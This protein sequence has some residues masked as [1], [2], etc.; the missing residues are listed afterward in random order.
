MTTKIAMTTIMTTTLKPCTSPWCSVRLPQNVIPIHYNLR[1]KANVNELS[2]NG[3][4]SMFVRVTN[5]TKYVLF[6]FKQ[7]NITE[8]KIYKM[9]GY[10]KQSVAIAGGQS[11]PTNEYF[12]IETTNQMQPGNY[13]V[14]VQFQALVSKKLTGFY[15]STYKNQ[16]GQTR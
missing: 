5:A 4:Q 8:F 9:D 3:T 12:V 2:F 11:K 7:M 1:I 14:E 10:S 13:E 6:H 16:N 15:R